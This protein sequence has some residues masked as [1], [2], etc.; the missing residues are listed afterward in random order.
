MV[1]PGYNAALNFENCWKFCLTKVLTLLFLPRF[2]RPFYHSEVWF[3][4]NGWW[5]KI[6]FYAKLYALSLNMLLTQWGFKFQTGAQPGGEFSPPQK[7]QNSNFDIFRNFQRIKI[8]FY[9]LIMKILFSNSEIF[10][11]A[12]C[13]RFGFVSNLSSE[14]ESLHRLSKRQQ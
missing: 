1:K 13:V 12:V 4:W 6:I 2:W 9:I 5:F 10:R 3:I 11:N 8:N 14:E 7:F